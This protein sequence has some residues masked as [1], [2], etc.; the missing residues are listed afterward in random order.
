M[1]IRFDGKSAIVT[2][3]GSGIG[4]AIARVLVEGG[5]RVTL[6]DRDEAAAQAV[7]GS[8]GDAA[9]AAHVD[10]A[11]AGSVEAM[12]AGAVAAQGALHLMV[13]NA[14]IGGGRCVT[15][16]FPVETWHEVIGINLTGTFLG[17]RFAIPAIR[18]AGGGA[19]LNV[20]SIL[21]LVGF[22]NTPAYVAAKHGVAGLT[23]TAALDHAADGIRVNAIAPGFIR[24]PLIET[25][26]EPARMAEVAALHPQNRLGTAEEV[27]ALAGFLLS[28]AASFITGSIHTVDGG[29][30]AR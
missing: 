23:K 28:D 25:R 9:R 11:D 14:G 17:L 19:V 27:A 29:Y 5:A 24:T 2:G 10:V 30:T 12:V 4:A 3:A 16:D 22:A 13:N 15:G 8:L 20:A 7:A 21:G 18:E 1:D 26:M 6:A